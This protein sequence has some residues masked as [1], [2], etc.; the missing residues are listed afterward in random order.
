MIHAPL[1]SLPRKAGGAIKGAR[2]V[3]R[4]AA[5]TVVTATD[6]TKSIAGVSVFDVDPASGQRLDVV[7]MGAV[8]VTYGGPVAEGDPLTTDG[9]GRAIKAAPGSGVVH[10]IGGFA[11]EDGVL[12]DLGSIVLSPAT[13]R[14]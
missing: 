13:I 5:G 12:G 3:T 14:G 11:A 4:S 10:F 2:F 1:L 6:P 9:E 7:K 8:P